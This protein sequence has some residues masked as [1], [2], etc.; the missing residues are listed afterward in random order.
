MLSFGKGGKSVGIFELPWGFAVNDHDEIAVTDNWNHRVSVFSNKGI[1]IYDFSFGRVDRKNG[2][3]DYPNGISFD[4]HS[5]IIV[6][7]RGNH[8][9]QVFDSNGNFLRTVVEQGGSVISSV[10]LN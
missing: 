7:D 8:T 9:V 1:Y 4:C 2:E 10:V 3:F 5:N 6:A